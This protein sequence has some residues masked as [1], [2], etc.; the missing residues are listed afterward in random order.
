MPHLL[1]YWSFEKH[2]F[3]SSKNMILVCLLRKIPVGFPYSSLVPVKMRTFKKYITRLIGI[4]FLF[5]GVNISTINSYWVFARTMW[6]KTPI[7]S[8]NA[9]FIGL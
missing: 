2:F 5:I 3:F 6:Y 8:A 1:A 9:S 7:N 4:R